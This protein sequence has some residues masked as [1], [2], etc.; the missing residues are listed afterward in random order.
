MGFVK[1][2][3]GRAATTHPVA[4]RA[5]GHTAA[6]AKPPRQSPP[7]PP[8]GADVYAPSTGRMRSTLPTQPPYRSHG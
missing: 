8:L 1:T 4:Q 2:A 3:A 7:L 5:V 6:H